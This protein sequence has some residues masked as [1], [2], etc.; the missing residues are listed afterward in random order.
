MKQL[1]LSPA[2]VGNT[3]P[4]RQTVCKLDDGKALPASATTLAVRVSEREKAR[5]LDQFYTRA[6]VVEDLLDWYRVK[7]IEHNLLRFQ[8]T[9]II[10]PSAGTGAFLRKLPLGSEGYD[11]DPKAPGI[12]QGNFFVLPLSLDDPLLVIGNPPFGKNASMAIKFFNRA[13]QAASVIAFIVPR[14][15]QK[16][17]VQNRLDL[18]FHLVDEILVPKDAF[19]FE[20]ERKHVPAVFQIWV[21]K[22]VRR[23]KIA[24]P[25]A[26]ADFEF[27][28]AG[29][30][31][32]ANF[33][34]QRVGAKAGQVHHNLE[35][36]PSAH[37]FIRAT[38]GIDD[39]EDAM[40]RLRLDFEVM[41]QR[42][43][44]KPSLAKTEVVQLYT[45]F[46]TSSSDEPGASPECSSPG[47]RVE[48]KDAI[49]S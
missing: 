15:F 49:C 31:H 7:R 2:D 1:S 30:A 25:K 39:L 45:Q 24:L 35:A 13:A 5:R 12:R 29:E 8:R 21:K 17:S 3:E 42:T 20:G 33:A 48:G 10:E 44:G 19:I 14:T 9:R 26:H 23:Q 6:E 36:K 38:S 27:L 18:S 47:R 34:I 16:V 40:C 4:G 11:I 37:Y 41:A 46:R 43:A 28:R 22:D 32:K